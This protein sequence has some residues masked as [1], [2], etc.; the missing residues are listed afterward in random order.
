MKKFALFSAV[1]VLTTVLTH[2][3]NG[4]LGV[5]DPGTIMLLIPIGVVFVLFYARNSTKQQ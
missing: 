1:A 5:E 2:L 4:W 3:I